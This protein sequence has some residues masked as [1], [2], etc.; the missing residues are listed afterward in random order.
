MNR[1]LSC[2]LLTASSVLF[3]I[4]LSGA[5]AANFTFDGV[6]L[7]FGGDAVAFKGDAVSFPDSGRIRRVVT[8]HPDSRPLAR[9]P[10]LSADVQASPD[11]LSAVFTLKGVPAD[12]GF[13][14]NTTML[15]RRLSKGLEMSTNAVKTAY[16]VRDS[17]GGIPYEVASGFVVEGCRS[18]CEPIRIVYDG[19]RKL[20]PR[21]NWCNRT[22]Q[23]I[24]FLERGDGTLVARLDVFRGSKWT[25][26]L[27][28]AYRDGRET[29]VTLS[30]PKVYNWFAD[31]RSPLEFTIR[32]LNASDRVKRPVLSWTV[33]DFDGKTVGRGS[34]KLSLDALSSLSRRC[35]FKPAAARG[36]FFVEASLGD[37]KGHELAFGRTNIV[38]LPPYEFKSPAESSVFGIANYWPIPDEDA[39]QTLMDR[40][41]VVWQRR[42]RTHPRH[43]RR[44]A[45][46]HDSGGKVRTM[47]PEK[48]AEWMKNALDACVANGNRLYE[49]GNEWNMSTAGIAMEGHGIGKALLGDTYAACVREMCA[50][51]DSDPKYAD[52]RLIS[53]GMAGC[54]GAFLKSIYRNG[55]WDKLDGICFHPGRGNFTPDYPYY[56]PETGL[57][58]TVD[59]PSSR[60]QM[61]HSNF[62]NFLG[63]VRKAKQIVSR[64]GEKPIWLTEVYA[65]TFPNS[66][67]EDTPR[68]AVDNVILTYALTQAEGIKC[69]MY[70]QLFDSRWIDRLGADPLDREY[71][72]G[73]VNRDLSFKPVLMGYCTIAEALDGAKFKG[74][75]KPFNKTTHALLFDTPRGGMA[76]VWDRTDGYVLTERVKGQRYRTPEPWLNRWK[77]HVDVSFPAARDAYAI[78][79]IG[80]KSPLKVKNGKAT[81]RLTGSPLIVYGLD[82]TG[83]GN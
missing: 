29:A 22:S 68:D 34:E 74:W 15:L 3:A 80:R 41:G 16:W 2:C 54:D 53:L 11:R 36:I 33:R 71:H 63:S 23:H 30:T 31:G 52:I 46:G 13:K 6:R 82:M 17:N 10:E 79:P 58:E 65:C 49:F 4:T 64:Y 37:E 48:R 7:T 81:L 75:M 24:R 47:P 61:R 9:M 5:D 60:E 12:S 21:L 43:P 62:W 67:W 35:T 66:D 51:R 42:G 14:T 20:R 73:L 83:G 59:M 8:Y 72:F 19:P 55:I 25:D 1:V 76:V 28:S 40:M 27:A 77:S 56:A 39:V 70:H 69:A 38:L 44:I 78:D 32:A 26:E 50:L 57:A 18:G 45:N